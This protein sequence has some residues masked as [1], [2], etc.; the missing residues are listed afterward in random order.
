MVFNLALMVSGFTLLIKGADIFV[1]GASKIAT[2]FNIPQ[3]VIGLT[4][5]AFGTSLPEAAVSISGALSDNAGIT[6]GNVL[7]SNIMNILVIL[8]V[9]SCI[10]AL[11]IKKNTL[12]IEIP[13]VIVITVLLLVLGMAGDELTRLDGIIFIALLAGFMVYLVYTAKHGEADDETTELTEKDTM[14]I[15]IGFVIIGAVC[16]VI[17]SDVTVDAASY[18]AAKCGM[19][20]RLIGLT[21]VAFGTS[22]PELVTSA[23][24]AKRGKVD[25]AIGNIVGSNIFN[26]LF[27]VGVSAVI[28]NIEF[29][30]AF[31][32]DAIV[33]TAAA[34]LL[35]VAAV[36]NKK[37]SRPAGIIMLLCY[38]AYFAYILAMNYA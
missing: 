24:A 21:V 16:I 27:V 2:K 17:G 35:F 6:V 4:I 22:L 38:A 37:L 29:E 32:K 15:L 3:M 5:V 28:T 8:G 18:I 11:P 14:P 13:F 36:K 10:A 7:G 1:D 26:I 12:R 34:V 25:I 20:P 33:A 23:T 30:V 9:S 19:T 31:I